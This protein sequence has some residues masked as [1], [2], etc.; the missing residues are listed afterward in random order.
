MNAVYVGSIACEFCLNRCEKCTNI[1]CNSCF[2]SP[3]CSL[4]S[5]K[6]CK[7]SFFEVCHICGSIACEFCLN[8]CEKCTNIFCNNCFPS[9]SLLLALKYCKCS[10]VEVN[11][12]KCNANNHCMP[13]IAATLHVFSVRSA[14]VKNVILISK[15]DKQ[16]ICSSCMSLNPDPVK[17]LPISATST[18]NNSRTLENTVI[19]GTGNMLGLQNIC[20]RRSPRS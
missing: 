14:S 3:S 13:Q 12:S 11:C 17:L 8:R 7:C 16:T 1:F 6:Y 10:S 5:T 2:K 4:C 20:S 9:C 19:P 18:A 15:P